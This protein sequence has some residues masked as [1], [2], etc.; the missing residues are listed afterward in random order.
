MNTLKEWCASAGARLPRERTTPDFIDYLE[1]LFVAHRSA[2]MTL[3][4]DSLEQKVQSAL[5]EIDGLTSGL[6]AAVREYLRGHPSR[7]YDALAKALSPVRAHL[8]ALATAP[9][10]AS[11][12]QPVYRVRVSSIPTRFTPRDLFH[13][14]FEHRGRVSS[15]RYSIN[16]LPCLYLGTSSYVC[17]EEMGRPAFSSLYIM[18]LRFRDPVPMLLDLVYIPAF[19]PGLIDIWNANGP[20]RARIESMIVA[21]T[22]CWPLIAACSTRSREPGAAFKPEYIVPQLLLQWI[23]QETPW[24]GVR[25]FSTRVGSPSG[26][27]LGANYVFPAR[28]D[29]VDGHCTELA[30][31]FDVSAV[32]NW[33]IALAVNLPQV[34]SEVR[35]NIEPAPGVFVEYLTTQ[36]YTV[37]S[38]LKACT[39][40][41]I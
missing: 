31:L 11:K 33:E 12:L 7:A 38:V 24:Y 39:A 8:D 30:Q 32:L 29:G 18:Q 2:L 35:G 19:L 14:P 6:L 22:I 13:I 40:A 34:G 27:W 28:T 26:I 16:G 37:E 23:T 21:L 3:T 5:P 17:W 41:P 36:F 1:K 25:Y 15:Q 4:P 10:D 20:S 9:P